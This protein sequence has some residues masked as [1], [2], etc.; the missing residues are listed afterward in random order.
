VKPSFSIVKRLTTIEPQAA[1]N[2]Q[3][4]VLGPSDLQK[5][6]DHAKN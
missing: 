1:R 5:Q 2:Y 6:N 4:A 3:L